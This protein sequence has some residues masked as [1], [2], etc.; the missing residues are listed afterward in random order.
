MGLAS[1]GMGDAASGYIL[2]PSVLNT[3]RITE[4]EWVMISDWV[5]TLEW[6]MPSDWVITFTIRDDLWGLVM[7]FGKDDGLWNG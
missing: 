3:L 4:R 7:T 1:T 6:V 2:F 5:R